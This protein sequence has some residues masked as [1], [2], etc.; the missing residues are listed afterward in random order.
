MIIIRLIIFAH[1]LN[2]CKLIPRMYLY[3]YNVCIVEA[4]GNAVLCYGRYI[5]LD[6]F[7]VLCYCMTLCFTV[8][9]CHK[10]MSLSM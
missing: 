5:V 10:V 6:Y 8:L 3:R 2:K 9:V 1:Y 7:Y 4:K